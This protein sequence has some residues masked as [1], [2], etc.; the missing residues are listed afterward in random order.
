MKKRLVLFIT[1]LV[2]LLGS[3]AAFIGCG[4]DTVNADYSV[5]VLSPD[6][7]PLSGISVTWKS[8]AKSATAVT[9]DDGKAT[10]TLPAA[11]YTVSLSGYGEGLT[12]TS[13]SVGSSM[14]NITLT[15]E[16]QQVKYTVTVIDKTGSPAANVT[17]SWTDDEK[18]V[19]TAVTD[20]NGVAE[21][22]LDYGEY[23]V[24]LANLPSGNI[25]DGA[26][27]VTGASP[28]ARFEL[29]DGVT[30]AYKVTVRSEGGLLFKKQPVMVYSGKAVVTSGLTDETGVYTASLVPGE[31]TVRASQIPDGYSFEPAEL[32]AS[33]TA[34]ELV[35]YSAVRTDEPS[36]GAD[37]YYVIGDIIHDYG[38]TT[39]YNVG[40]KPWSSSVAEILET[41]KKEALI[42]NNWGTNCS[43]CVSEMPEMQELY[44]KYSD[45][46][47]IVA[48]SNYIPYDND[49][50]IIDYHER[51]DYTFPLLRDQ[52]GFTIKFQI[53][54]WPTTVIVDRY[55][56][57]ARIEV[58]AILGFE[59]WERMILKYIGD[60]YVQTFTPG[61]R[62][63]DSINN[64]VSKPDIVLPDDHYDKVA[65]TINN[66]EK[67]PDGASVT[68]FGETEVDY[69]WPFVLATEPDVSPEDNVLCASN[70]GKAN[71]MAAIYATV[72]VKAGKVFTFDYYSSTQAN[73]DVLTV[74]WDG[75]I[76][77]Q[78]SGESNGWQT[79]YLYADIL[80]GKHTLAM[81]Y[82][83][84]STIN[85]GKDNV[86]FR[87]VRFTELT[88]IEGSSDMFRAAAYGIPD[89]GADRFLHYA[90]V[91]IDPDDGYYHVDLSKLE[92]SELAG[93]DESPM[94]FMNML[95]ATNWSG[96]SIQEY[97][98][99]KLETGEY[100][101][102]CT[103]TVNNVTKDYREDLTEYLMMANA[104][105]VEDC[106]PV[107]KKLHD[108]IVAF[109]AHLSG[110]HA[111]ADEWLE[112]CYFYSH[113]GD[114]KPIGNPIMGVT[115]NTAV[116]VEANTVYTADLTRNMFPFPTTIFAFTPKTSEVYKIESLI[117]DEMADKGYSAQIWLYDE[118]CSD[119]EYILH[120][121]EENLKRDAKNE[122]NF[123]VYH[124]MEAGHKYYI[125]LAFQMMMGGE[126]DFKITPVGQSVTYLTP[127][128]YDFYNQVLDEDGN[129]S[130]YVVLAGAIEYKMDDDGY[131]HALNDDGTLGDFIYLD[132]K[133]AN[134]IALSKIPLNKLVDKYETDP[135]DFTDLDYHIFDFRYKVTYT[136]TI[137]PEGDVIDYSPKT[138][139]TS[140]GEQYKDYTARLKEIIATAPTSG[141]YEGLI[142]VDQEIVDIL[143]LFIETRLNTTLNGKTDPVLENEWLRF[144]WYNKTVSAPT[145]TPA[146]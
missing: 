7:A 73:N 133:Y 38:F 111:H 34:T 99:G 122:Q 60:D 37:D 110:D 67:F 54:N 30:A 33:V 3:F 116:V 45:K 56:A 80:D 117:P 39:P 35:L 16:E 106:V 44:E 75:M 51:Y 78:I 15:L 17:A 9:D 36:Y 139:L 88:D 140:L 58:G 28:A 89:G 92:N 72:N 115:E 76:V 130:G 135:K 41:N 109:M 32:S 105:K 144:C 100:A 13:V 40:D 74:I 83:K 121:G 79:C 1:A 42:I 10:T 52:N 127:C 55:G 49:Q 85:R 126:Y 63:S 43:W 70:S 132:V 22:E 137:G 113:Y 107:D 98:I 101:F 14:R 57:I 129:W 69:I 19:G 136:V 112:A 53:E 6:E 108:L 90:Q 25:Y 5:T 84:N 11:T 93:N 18:I 134:T 103:F 71:S 128:S 143:K 20:T 24:T 87:N 142:K 62:V 123:E 48:V 64:E 146:E 29:H 65:D 141:E 50:T 47:E 102:D 4:S 104:S 96:H 82:V 21:C 61:D 91:A 95:N 131:Y 68:W 145:A 125:M 46:I 77:K 118:G 12:Y 27:T 97:V 114:G 81:A 2:I 23:S 8:S 138:D 31:Y 119:D 94:L 66:T 59:A 124:Y 120:W 26:A 86:Y